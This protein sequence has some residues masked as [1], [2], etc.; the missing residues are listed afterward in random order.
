MH[1]DYPS[2]SVECNYEPGIPD[3]TAIPGIGLSLIPLGLPQSY[4][5][6]ALECNFEPGVPDYVGVSSIGMSVIANNHAETF[7][8]LA[9]QPSNGY[10]MI[11]YNGLTYNQ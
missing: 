9:I 5:S 7:I 10:V 1:L 4:A 8:S 11:I 2:L 6:L 3:F